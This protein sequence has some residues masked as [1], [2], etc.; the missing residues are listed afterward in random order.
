MAGKQLRRVGLL[1]PVGKARGSNAS[2]NADAALCVGPSDRPHQSGCVTIT[3]NRHG[4]V[5]VR[6]TAKMVVG[7]GTRAGRAVLR[8]GAES[9]CRE[10]R[11][12]TVA[13]ST[14]DVNSGYLPDW[15]LE[16]RC[17]SCGCELVEGQRRGKYSC[18]NTDNCTFRIS[19]QYVDERR[20]RI[21]VARVI[22]RHLP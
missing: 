19:R 22:A 13:V 2:T 7:G 18:S 4:Y 16:L 5:G 14:L 6:G 9:N 20:D 3:C 11:E 10:S 1:W 8:M 15:A 12:A 21:L 17:P